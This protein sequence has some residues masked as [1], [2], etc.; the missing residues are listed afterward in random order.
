[1]GQGGFEEARPAVKW[2]VVRP[3]TVDTWS[4]STDDIDPRIHVLEWLVSLQDAG[5]PQGGVFDPFRDTWSLTVP[6]TSV[7]A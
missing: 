7:T 5:Q 2:V 6:G 3:A 1:M 4:A